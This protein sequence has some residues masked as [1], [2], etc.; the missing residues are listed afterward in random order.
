MV[1]LCLF[2]EIKSFQMQINESEFNHFLN[3]C[4]TRGTLLTS[5]KCCDLTKLVWCIKQVFIGDAKRFNQSQIGLHVL[6]IINI[7]L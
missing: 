7:G 5:F 3:N 6:H 2:R 4:L 1:F